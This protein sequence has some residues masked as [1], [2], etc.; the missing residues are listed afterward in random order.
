MT[1]ALNLPS[2]VS[3]IAPRHR[4]PT[5]DRSRRRVQVGYNPSRVVQFL[6]CLPHAWTV[7][8]HNWVASGHACPHNFGIIS[9]SAADAFASQSG[10][11]SLIWQP[12][13]LPV[14]VSPTKET[15]NKL[16]WRFAVIFHCV[17][18]IW[19]F[20]F[21]FPLKLIYCTNQLLQDSAVKN[22]M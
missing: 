13:K 17:F 18:T 7:N 4:L 19:Q 12:T 15:K 22:S 20:I 8:I 2:Y 6:S 10:T 1:H 21:W 11:L 16:G 5:S 9:L 14:K 3:G